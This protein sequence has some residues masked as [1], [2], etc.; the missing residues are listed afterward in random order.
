MPTRTTY[1]SDDDVA[2]FIAGCGITVPDGFDFVGSAQ[3]GIDAFEKE[4]G[5]IPFLMDQTDQ[6]FV[7]D[8]PGSAPNARLYWPVSGGGRMLALQRGLLAVTSISINGNV[9]SPSS[10][11]LRPYNAPIE[12]RPY[13][14]IEFQTPYWG[15]N[16][17]LV[18]LGRGGYAATL[19]EDAWKAVRAL[20]ASI[21]ARDLLQGILWSP[22]TT[23]EGDETT[24]QDDSRDIG[25]GWD[26][27][28]ARVIAKY[29]L[30]TVG[31]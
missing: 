13:T 7:Y 20:A 5:R 23:K 1:P 21:R 27:Y 19:P 12:N 22:S 26:E 11:K 14:M 29:R 3:E 31:I 30:Q 6:E 2:A 16:G 15:L 28:S 10:Y 4:T 18:I 24:I 9:I 25:K 17:D 8:L